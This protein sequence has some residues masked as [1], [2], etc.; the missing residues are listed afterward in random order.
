MITP[1][2]YKIYQFIQQHIEKNGF[3]PSLTEIAV[4]I[5]ISPNSISLVSRAIRSLVAAGKLKAH[6]KGYRNIEIATQSE[7]ALPLMGRIAAGIP[8]EAIEDKQM[9]DL[10]SLFK[11]E[12][13]FVLQ[14][15][16]NS[17]IEDG[18]F[19]GDLIICRR[20]PAAHENDIV[21]AL[22]DNQDVTL[23]HISYREKDRITLVPANPN[24]QAKS[25]APEQ[26]QIQGLFVGLL[27]FNKR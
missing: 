25:Y 24:L 3:S 15:S 2:Q 23:K 4:G 1:V 21:V 20:T 9:V 26:V 8:I 12:D 17:M 16:G 18:I 22:I 14:V 13:C 10:A 27:R 11:S 19:D 7:F 5:G 6:K